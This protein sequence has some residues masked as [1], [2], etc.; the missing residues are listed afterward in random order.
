MAEATQVGSLYYDLDIDSDNLDKSL[1][2]SDKSV[3]DFGD[4]VGETGD[5]I[6]SVFNKVALG[7]A[8]IGA[9]LTIVSKEATDFTI[10]LVKDSTALGRQLG[11]TTEEASRLTAGL[12]RMGLT[13]EETSQM[14]GIFQKNIV[15]AT[16]DT[17]KNRI[18][19]DKLR[20]QIESTK[21]EIQEVSAEIIKSGDKSGEL[22]L[23]VRSLSNTLASQE[24]QLKQNSNAFDKLGVSVVDS[25]GKQKDFM[26]ILFEAADKFKA[27]PNGIDKTAL[28]LDLFGRSGKD[29]VKVLNLG[30]Q[31]IK[32]L[33]DQADKLGLTLKESTITRISEL[34]QSQ[35]DLKEQT[36]IMKIA[37]GTATAPVLTK[38]NNF[39]NDIIGTLLESEGALK[40]V[41]VAVLAFG[42]PVASAASAVFAFGAN[43]GTFIM[44]LKELN[45]V[46]RIVAVAQWLFNAALA[47]NPIILIALAIIGLI[48]LFVLLFTHWDS[49]REQVKKV[50]GAIVD[51]LKN[52]WDHI[53]DFFKG[54]PKLIGDALKPIADILLAPYKMAFKAIIALWNN[55]LGRIS[56]KAP[57]WIPGIGGKGWSFPKFAKGAIATGPTIGMFGEAGTEAVLPLTFLDHYNNLFNRIEDVSKG[58]S[59]GKTMSNGGTTV[60]NIGEVND[61]SD[62]DYILRRLDRS[63]ERVDMGLSPA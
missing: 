39:M 2:S 49:F 50:F 29:M 51:T 25:E 53:V 54:L 47:A 31:G 60:V 3:K 63:Q 35:K 19:N 16:T 10:Q 7:L 23:K 62:A 11:I 9:G 8:A 56:F 58:L 32:D 59:T 14:F 44:F 20:L 30:S 17:N 18:A 28:A 37:I 34:I 45:I 55:T 33:E 41:T 5:K 13:S 22:D 40:N 52:I 21:R 15:A 24:D 42:G 36:D 57:D 26:S 27:M 43:L 61:R 1:E 4:S 38:F 6:K 46:T 12:K 48:A